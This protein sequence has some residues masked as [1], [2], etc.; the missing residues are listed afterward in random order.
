MHIIVIAL[1]LAL[2]AAAL[3]WGS[4][5]HDEG[6]SVESLTL[7]TFVPFSRSFFNTVCAALR[8]PL[9]E[10]RAQRNPHGGI[11]DLLTPPHA[12]HPPDQWS[13]PRGQPDSR[14][15]GSWRP[16]QTAGSGHHRPRWERRFHCSCRLCCFLNLIIPLAVW[17]GVCVG[18]VM[19]NI[20]DTN[21]QRGYFTA[22]GLGSEFC[23][24]ITLYLKL[25]TIM[26]LF[27]SSHA[28]LF[29]TMQAT[30]S[31]SCTNYKCQQIYY[32]NKFWI[33]QNAFLG[34]LTGCT[35]IALRVSEC[36]NVCVS[37]LAVFSEGLLSSLSNMADSAICWKLFSHVFFVFLHSVPYLSFAL[38]PFP[39]IIFPDP[40]IRY[41]VLA[42]LDE[43]FDAHLAQAE[44]LQAL[45]VALNDEV[46]EIR[47]L[48]ICT[49]GRLSSMNPAFVMPFLRKMLIQV[50]IYM[51]YT[52]RN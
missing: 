25:H 26:Q 3:C 16:Q 11:T 40:D 38:F 10:Q 17:S 5:P 6:P 32:L 47:E 14:A 48:A 45:F 33:F 34:R 20:C 12:F 22:P 31:L 37:L 29:L 9:P 43:R 49:I 28:Y 7:R 18:I 52:N 8:R 41:C 4:K 15:G 27:S 30:E 35:N 42:S 36:V 23:K 24:N 21:W 39:F 19:T 51:F 50:P 13:R 2:K 46:F 44:N 1:I